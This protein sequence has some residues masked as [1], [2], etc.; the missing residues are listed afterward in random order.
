MMDD[1]DADIFEVVGVLQ[2]LLHGT[3]VVSFATSR[4]E[5]G[6]ADRRCQLL[7]LQRQCVSQ[8]ADNRRSVERRGVCKRTARAQHHRPWVV[9]DGSKT[10][11][12]SEGALSREKRY[13]SRYLYF[14]ERRWSELGRLAPRR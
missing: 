6:S 1:G 4:L 10:R 13:I 5:H 8:H 11:G 7:Q 9:N 3:R 12:G 2:Q 14:E